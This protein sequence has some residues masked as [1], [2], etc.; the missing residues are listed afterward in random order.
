MKESQRNPHG[1]RAYRTRFDTTGNDNG[2]SILLYFVIFR[3]SIEYKTTS[4]TPSGYRVIFRM[5]PWNLPIF[6]KSSHTRKWE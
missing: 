4:Q 5:S 1:R 6:L 3:V 2:I